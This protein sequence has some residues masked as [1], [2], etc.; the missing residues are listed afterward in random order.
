MTAPQSKYNI[1]DLIE[2]DVAG[3]R[4]EPCVGI[5]IN[6]KSLF[7]DNWGGLYQYEVY[8]PITDSAY[9]YNENQL[10]SGFCRKLERGV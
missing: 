10:N 2:A 1:G 4:T 9:W 5:I 7:R 6:I 3:S 8:W